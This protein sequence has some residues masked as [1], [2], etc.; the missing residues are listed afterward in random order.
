MARRE[1]GGEGSHL[2]DFVR[3]LENYCEQM[4]RPIFVLMDRKLHDQL[5]FCSFAKKKR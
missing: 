5:R 2:Q 1:E 3:H 4:P